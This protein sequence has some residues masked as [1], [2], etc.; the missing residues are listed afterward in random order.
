MT[1]ATTLFDRIAFAA[2][3]LLLSALPLSAVMFVA[4]SF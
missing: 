2:T 3:A 1:S 4:P